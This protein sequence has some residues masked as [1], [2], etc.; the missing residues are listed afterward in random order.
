RHQ[1]PSLS[2]HAAQDNL[3]APPTDPYK[4]GLM[5]E[6][7]ASLPQS[8]F[9]RAPCFP[10]NQSSKD[11]SPFADEHH[12]LQAFQASVHLQSNQEYHLELETPYLYYEHTPQVVAVDIQSLPRFLL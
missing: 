6:Q 8:V 12:Y 5:K 4:Q 3:P 1:S 11:T 10:P 2:I 7:P 9:R